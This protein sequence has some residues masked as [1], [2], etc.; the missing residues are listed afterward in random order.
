MDVSM[1]QAM[2]RLGPERRFIVAAEEVK[3]VL[4]GERDESGGAPRSSSFLPLPLANALS[5]KRKESYSAYRFRI[6]RLDDGR[7]IK[8]E[9]RGALQ[10]GEGWGEITFGNPA[11]SASTICRHCTRALR[12]PTVLLMARALVV[13]HHIALWILVAESGWW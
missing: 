13:A 3:V 8:F 2:E 7:E 5:P 6:T 9:V 11:S 10:R 4:A 12:G 1:K